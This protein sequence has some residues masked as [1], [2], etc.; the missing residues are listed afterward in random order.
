MNGPQLTDEV[1]LTRS[2]KTAT[3]TIQREAARNALNGGV[4]RGLVAALA[5]VRDD[6]DVISVVIT[7]A[8]AKAFCAGGDLGGTMSGGAVAQHLDRSAL[9]ELFRT[10]RTLG[11]PIV[12]RLNGHALGGGF[13]LALACDLIVAAEHAQLGTPE[14]NLGLWPYIITAV[15][16]RNIPDKVALD[17]MLRGKRIDADTAM[18]WGMVNEVVSADRLDETVEAVLSEINSKSPL[19]LR[20]GKDSFYRARD[21]SFDDAL[22]YLENQL[23][24]GLSSEDALEGV[25]AFIQK[26]APEWKGR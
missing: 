10:M 16:Q 11:K 14:I 21:M 22:A 13:G 18:K 12:A 23:T 4:M 1:V 26:R 5:E 15:I 20:L 7:G 25:A 3:V 9:S 24:I 19:V 2:G 17:M 6:P 8:G